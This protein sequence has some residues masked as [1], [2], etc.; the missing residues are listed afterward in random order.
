MLACTFACAWL[1]GNASAQTNGQRFTVTGSGQLQDLR[2]VAAG[3]IN[4][5]GTDLPLGDEEDPQ[6]GTVTLQDKFVFPKGSLFVTSVGKIQFTFNP[7]TCVRSN[8]FSG[9]YEITGG[10][11]AYEGITGTGSF[12][13]RL[14]FIERGRGGCSDEGGHGVLVINYTGSILRSSLQAA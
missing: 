6:T 2:V 5:V 1:G 9:T 14:L 10:T 13:G 11:G 7:R 8:T 4:A 3:T 12:S